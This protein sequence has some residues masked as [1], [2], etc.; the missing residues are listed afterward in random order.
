[1]SVNIA[2]FASGRGSNTKNICSY[3]SSS[4][5]IRVSLICSNTSSS[6]V[7]GYAK[8]KKI[9]FYLFNKSMLVDFIGLKRSLDFYN[10][11]LIVLAGFLL[12]VP[13]KMILCYPK[14]IINLH[15]SLLPKYG[16]KG[17]YG[18][19]VHQAVIN[20]K[21]RESGISIHF[22]NKE[23]DQGRVI[24]QKKCL[25][26]KNE[27]PCSLEKKIRVLELSYFPKIIEQICLSL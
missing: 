7:L 18:K 2:V 26:A 16:G 1:M 23:F 13:E 24:F 10:I 25:V 14:K 9:P 5:K 6:G 12:K 11:N 21:E 19:H 20:A 4:S 27:T 15:P 22:V 3:F 17:M 8:E